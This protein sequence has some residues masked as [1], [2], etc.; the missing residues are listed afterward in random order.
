MSQIVNM[1]R[2]AAALA[3]TL[4]CCA[5]AVAPAA[6][7]AASSDATI[8]SVRPPAHVPTLSSK[9]PAGLSQGTTT[10]TTTSTTSTTGTTPTTT[11]TT[12]AAG[13]LPHTGIDLELDL[14]LGAAMLAGGL[15]LRRVWPAMR[16]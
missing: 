15:T 13:G 10:T 7:Q 16:S 2:P 4:V 11:A 12:P 5:A 3:A 1:S 9:P 8:S 6:S 14:L